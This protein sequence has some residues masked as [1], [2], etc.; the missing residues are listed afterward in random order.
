MVPYGPHKIF[1]HTAT[2]NGPWIEFDL[3]R[4]QRVG[5]VEVWNRSD[6]CMERAAPLVVETS[7]DD[8]HW[9]EVAR[10]HYSFS[11]WRVSFSSVEARYVRL[12]V[13]K[14]SQLHLESVAIR[15]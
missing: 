6:C 13:D 10:R 8:A 11:Y 3:S 15:H 14:K 5:A 1:F 7:M 12:R 2:E 4:P 9:R